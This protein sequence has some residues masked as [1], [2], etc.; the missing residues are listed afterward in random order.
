MSESHI[1]ALP[2]IV[3]AQRGLLEFRLQSPVGGSFVSQRVEKWKSG[4]VE[5]WKS[6][7]V[8]E[9]KSRKDVKTLKMLIHVQFTIIHVHISFNVNCRI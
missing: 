5:E 6:G 2:S 7:R 1:S 9:W 4:R 8:E 3:G